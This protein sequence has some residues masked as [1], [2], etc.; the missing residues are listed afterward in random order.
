MR[1]LP[2]PLDMPD[3]LAQAT[4]DVR[5]ILD[6][7]ACPWCRSK[8]DVAP[9]GLRC[10]GCPA[11]FPAHE[12][13]LDLARRGTAETWGVGDAQASSQRYQEAYAK[14]DRAQDYNRAYEVRPLKRM[15]TARERRLIARLLGQCGQ[16]ETLLELPCGGGR[17]SPSFAPWTKLLIQADTGW[18]QLLHA[19]QRPP[20]PAPR[21]LMSASGFHIPFR[22]ASLDGVACVRLNHHLPTIEERHR[23]LGE[24]LRVAKRYVLMTFFD[25]ASVKNR[26]RMG[27]GKPPK[28]TM[29]S[30]EVAGLAREH[31]A[32]L[33]EAPMI[34]W[35]N[36]GHRYA[37]MVKDR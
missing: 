34:S 19:N 10:T 37:L 26:V 18:G 15:S 29:T 32:K 25:H 21:V 1:Q 12:G 30:G 27:L 13:I 9:S 5:Q 24:L 17:L 22:D 33:V 28:L 2:E 7:L 11:E 8:L 14:L 20:L 6:L 16:V 4:P 36:S 35:L 23:L 31:G 3:V